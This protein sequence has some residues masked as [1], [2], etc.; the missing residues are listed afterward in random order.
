MAR[1]AFALLY[2]MSLNLRLWTA[3]GGAGITEKKQLLKTLR[4]SLER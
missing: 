4:D 1:Y 2:S 3:C